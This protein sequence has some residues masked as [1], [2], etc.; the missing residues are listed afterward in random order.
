MRKGGREGNIVKDVGYG[1]RGKKRRAR[2]GSGASERGRTMTDA[3]SPKI[4]RR[5]AA[6]PPPLSFFVGLGL[7]HSTGGAAAAAAESKR[8]SG[9]A[10]RRCRRRRR[11]AKSGMTVSVHCTDRRKGSGWGSTVGPRT[12]ASKPTFPR[13]RPISI[14]LGFFAPSQLWSQISEKR[15][16]PSRVLR[17]L[18]GSTT[19]QPAATSSPSPVRR[20]TRRALSAVVAV[21]ALVVGRA[22]LWSHLLP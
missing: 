1:A 15:L 16:R 10:R 18:H 6:S 9:R 2:E 13:N 20:A 14:A 17:C 8:E 19:A 3:I 12:D 5:L 4:L 7:S 22:K 11:I 21:A